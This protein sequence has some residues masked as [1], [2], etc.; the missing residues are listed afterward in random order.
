MAVACSPAKGSSESSPSSANS[1][2]ISSA[3]APSL[4]GSTASSA[5]P[6][7]KLSNSR[8]SSFSSGSFSK[9]MTRSPVTEVL[10]RRHDSDASARAH[11]ERSPGEGLF[12]ARRPHSDGL[13][14]QP[15]EELWSS[16]KSLQYRDV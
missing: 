11:R 8:S 9:S 2:E 16:K 12:R 13:R 14:K 4:A 15:R 5:I 7:S 6:S 1:R 10:N 3:S